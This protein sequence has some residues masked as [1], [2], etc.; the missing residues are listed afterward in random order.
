MRLISLVKNHGRTTY[1]WSGRRFFHAV[2]VDIENKLNVVCDLIGANFDLICMLGVDI[3]KI[4]EDSDESLMLFAHPAL[5]IGSSFLH[6]DFSV[7]FKF[8]TVTFINAQESRL[9]AVQ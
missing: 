4:H 1:I 5:L 3:T 9:I 8:Y 7:N 6:F 2:G